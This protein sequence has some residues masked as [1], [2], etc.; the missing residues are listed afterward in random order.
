MSVRAVPAGWTLNVPTTSIEIQSSVSH[1]SPTVYESHSNTGNNEKDYDGDDDLS[2][3]AF[4]EEMLRKDEAKRT[5]VDGK[6][7]QRSIKQKQWRQQLKRTQQYLGLCA[8]PKSVA[9]SDASNM[10]NLPLPNQSNL[11]TSSNS[12]KLPVKF[13]SIDVEAYEFNQK[14]V[15]EIGISTLENVD[16]YGIPPGVNGKD[17]IAKVKS[18]HFRIHE[19]GHLINKVHVEG[20]PDKFNFGESEWIREQDVKSTLE[21]YFAPSMPPLW[22]LGKYAQ[23][24]YK[25]ILVAHNAAADIKY[26]AE[27]G[28]NV[29]QKISDCIDT[30][31]LYKVVRR[32]AKDSALSSLLLHYRIAARFLHN[33]GNDASY[34]LRVMV[35]IAVHTFQNKKSKEDWDIEKDKRIQLA[36]KEAEAKAR[37]D[38]E[39]WSSCE[40]D[41]AVASSAKPSTLNRRENNIKGPMKENSKRP[42]Q[43]S[44]L[45]ER[46]VYRPQVGGTFGTLPK[47]RPPYRTYVDGTFDE[48]AVQDNPKLQDVSR[49][50]LPPPQIHNNTVPH[51]ATVIK[52]DITKPNPSGQGR[53]R[54][55]RR[56]RGQGQSQADGVPGPGPVQVRDQ[57]RRQARG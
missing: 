56:G 45:Q 20:C 31:D 4:R 1:I 36:I 30:A 34:T 54:N 14:R 17:W 7:S 49:P 28:F 27:L 46:P 9:G 22:A 43:P 16:L 2:F 38:F 11:G 55:R 12:S 44:R 13:V 26:F 6:Q 23:Q 37:A 50:Y 33:A 8:T 42:A 32:E 3:Q 35:A 52:N 40:D 19:H 15:T 18:R 39:G 5:K 41:E 24:S 47:G 51:A 10:E 25:L 48:V 53:G 29:T 57:N 21:Q